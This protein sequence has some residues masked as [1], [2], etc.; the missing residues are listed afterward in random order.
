ME[1]D[2]VTQQDLKKLMDAI[3]RRFGIVL[4]EIE[5]VHKDLEEIKKKLPDDDN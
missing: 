5:K 3:V 2:A 4:N 1:E